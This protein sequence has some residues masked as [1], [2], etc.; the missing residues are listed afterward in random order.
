MLAIWRAAYR[1]SGRSVRFAWGG[2]GW[3]LSQPAA[4]LTEKHLDFYDFL[5]ATTGCPAQ[6]CNA[7]MSWPAHYHSGGRGLRLNNAHADDVVFGLFMSALNVEAEG[8]PASSRRRWMCWGGAPRAPP[9]KW[10]RRA[11]VKL[12]A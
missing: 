6:T 2:A 7:N 3:A 1:R 12:R 5:V 4:E 10:R 9:Q 11:F 8:L